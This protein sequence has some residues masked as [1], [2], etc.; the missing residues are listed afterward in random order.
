MGQTREK[1]PNVVSIGLARGRR[2]GGS[3]RGTV[4]LVE[5]LE[6]DR[7]A[8]E[9]VLTNAGM[10][11]VS[12]TDEDAGLDLVV[13]EDPRVIVASQTLPSGIDSFIQL[14]KVMYAGRGGSPPVVVLASDGQGRAGLGVADD[15]GT[16][17]LRKPVDAEELVKAVTEAGRAASVS[18]QAVVKEEEQVGDY[19]G[20]LAAYETPE[21]IAAFVDATFQDIDKTVQQLEALAFKPDADAI[22]QLIHAL[23][24]LGKNIGANE[25]ASTCRRLLDGQRAELLANYTAMLSFLKRLVERERQHHVKSQ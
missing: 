25:L 6:S 18:P 2:A 14:V 20:E 8:V 21:F 3:Q 19:L 10:R 9:R 15:A 5:P 22:W 12:A 7:L 16:T 13:D 17:A 23:H 11:V 4:L 24:G 1:D